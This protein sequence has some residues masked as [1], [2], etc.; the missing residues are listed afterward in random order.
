MTMGDRIK[1]RQQLLDEQA[2]ATPARATPSVD[3]HDHSAD[4]HRAP[5]STAQP[6]QDGTNVPGSVDAVQ[7]EVATLRARM[8]VIKQEVTDEVN[9]NWVSG[10]R[11]PAMIQLKVKTRLTGH[12]EYRSLQNRVR[13]A[14]ACLPPESD[15]ATVPSTT[16]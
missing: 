12:Q 7:Q 10:W 13:D 2:A 15:A 4:Y 5:D 9:R 16:S 11:T 14:Q 1:T 6:M 3:R 8:T